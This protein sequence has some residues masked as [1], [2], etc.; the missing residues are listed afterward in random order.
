MSLNE[1]EFGEFKDKM[2]EYISSDPFHE[3]LLRSKMDE[4]EEMASLL[5]DSFVLIKNSSLNPIE[6]NQIVMLQNQALSFKKAFNCLKNDMEKLKTN[7]SIGCLPFYDPLMN[8]CCQSD[9]SF[10]ETRCN[11]SI[12]VEKEGQPRNCVNGH[13]IESQPEA[14]ISFQ[15]SDKIAFALMALSIILLALLL[16]VFCNRMRQNRLG[17][18]TRLKVHCHLVASMLAWYLSSVL[19]T[20]IHHHLASESSIVFDPAALESILPQTGQFLLDKELDSQRFNPSFVEKMVSIQKSCIIA[21]FLSHFFWLAVITWSFIEALQL[22]YVYHFSIFEESEAPTEDTLVLSKCSLD[23][24]VKCDLFL[25]F[26]PI[27]LMLCTG[28]LALITLLIN[29]TRLSLRVNRCRSEIFLKN[30]K[31][32]LSLIVLFGIVHLVV[33]FHF[34][35]RWWSAFINILESTQ[36]IFMTLFWG[37]LTSEFRSF[38]KDKIRRRSVR[39][40]INT[41]NPKTASVILQVERACQLH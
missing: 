8:I 39:N 14:S 32:V 20:L 23:G 4:K 37:I 41:N 28:F 19:K 6:K 27:N 34:D 33:F 18:T 10:C 2:A 40:S 24:N 5:R 26:L 35:A 7:D 31:S 12:C 15:N 38:F 30:A 9:Q 17:Q 22:L 3:S 21:D 36:G 11:S 1:T 13:W 25:N 16:F 29:I